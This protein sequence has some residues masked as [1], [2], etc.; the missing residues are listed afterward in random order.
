MNRSD[1]EQYLRS[2]E[3][4]E[5]RSAALKRSG[6][7]CQDCLAERKMR[8]VASGYLVWPAQEVHHLTYERVGDELP[9]DLVALCGRHH[10][11][12]HGVDPQRD[13]ELAAMKAAER[14]VPEWEPDFSQPEPIV[15]VAAI[16]GV[17]AREIPPPE[18][19]VSADAGTLDNPRAAE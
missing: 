2:P 10:R 13:R 5:R 1:Y 8:G 7:K 19:E 15:N 14:A 17:T 18:I 12:R 4:R 3:W 16:L 11:A 9:E 6:G